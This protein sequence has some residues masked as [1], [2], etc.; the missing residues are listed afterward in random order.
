MTFHW[1]ICLYFNHLGCG[2]I[3][4][5][6]GQ[7]KNIDFSSTQACSCRTLNLWIR[8]L[9]PFWRTNTQLYK[10]TFCMSLLDWEA[11]FLSW[12]IDGGTQFFSLSSPSFTNFKR[13]GQDDNHSHAHTNEGKRTGRTRV[14]TL[15]ETWRRDSAF[16]A[17]AC[18][19]QKP[20]HAFLS[21]VQNNLHIFLIDLCS[22]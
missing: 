20:N 3:G 22:P 16:L 1:L 19:T 10:P 4:T 11:A 14:A 8:R 7:A 15:V 17:C 2:V 6:Y 9:L 21:S 18:L 12:C 5:V 13:K